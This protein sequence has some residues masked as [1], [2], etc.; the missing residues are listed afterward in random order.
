MVI[1]TVRVNRQK[2]RCDEFIDR[3]TCLDVKIYVSSRQFTINE[4]TGNPNRT[5]AE[6]VGVNRQL[7]IVD[8]EPLFSTPQS[9][10]AESFFYL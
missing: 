2:V 5:T 6:N 9:I 10:L 1:T 7:S 4:Q 8:R 3:L